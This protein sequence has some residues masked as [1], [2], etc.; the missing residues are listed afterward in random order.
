MYD[1]EDMR[2]V[3]DKLR[4]GIISWVFGPDYMDYLDYIDYP[5]HTVYREILAVGIRYQKQQHDDEVWDITGWF[6]F[7][8]E[9][10]AEAALEYIEYAFESE[11]S[12]TQIS[13]RLSGQ[14]IEITGEKEIPED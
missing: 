8:S 1:N 12:P 6:K 13:S 3:A 7:D 4:S 11:F 14:Y 2:A 9:A 10:S 5:Y